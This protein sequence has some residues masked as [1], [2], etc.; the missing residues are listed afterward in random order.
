MK[1]ILLA[2][3][4]VLTSVC[5]AA[6]TPE[7]IRGTD[8]R[9][10]ERWVDS[11]YRAM[12]PRQRVAQIICGKAVPTQGANSRAA[13]KRLVATHR[14]GALLFTS[15]SLAQHIEMTNY[16]QSIAEVP[17]LMTFDGEWG[18]AMRMEGT[19]KFPANMTLGAISDPQLL[20][21][22][23][24]EVG[25]QCRLAGI[26]VNFAPDVD[27][28]SNPRNPVIGHRSF[29]EDP[30]RVATAG[31]AYARGLEHAGVLSVAKHFPGHGDTANDSHKE[32]VRVDHSRQH[33]DDVDLLPFR[34]YIDAGLSGVMVGHIAVPALDPSGRPASMSPA[35]TGMLRSGLRFEGLIFTDALEMKGARLPGHNSALEALRA[36]ADILLSSGNPAA[37]INAITA[38]LADGSLDES[39]ISDRC[40]RVLRYKYALGL[41]SAPGH[42]GIKG[43]EHRLDSPSSRAT[44]DRLAAG[45]I[46]VLRNDAG[47]LPIGGLATA[48]IAVVNIGQPAR[49][50]F[51][52]VCSRYALTD[53][54]TT[55]LSE[56]T[57]ARL[58]GYDVVIAAVYSDNAAARN[59]YGRLSDIKGLVSVF[60]VSPYKM[61]KFHAAIKPAK[62]LVLA[63]EPL[64]C[65]QQA[66]AMAIF[67]G[68]TTS[69]RLPVDLPGI[70]PAGTGLRLRKSRLG[71]SS[72]LAEGLDPALTDSI[73][74]IIGNAL[75]AGAFPGAQVLVARHGNIVHNRSYGRL[76]TGGA[77]VTDSTVYDLAS[78]SKAVGTL[79]GV[80]KAV[81]LGLLRLEKPAADYIPGLKGT[82]KDSITLR[83]LL[84]HE[85]AMPAALNMFNVM[86]DSTSYTGKLITPRR[87]RS[88]TI[89]IYRG[90]WGNSSARLRSDIISRHRSPA[91]PVEAARG[92]W[93]G[94]A[95]FDTIMERI[96]NIPL[97]DTPRYNYSCLNFCLLMDAEQRVTGLPH[98]RWVR[99]SI[100]APLG[101]ATICYRPSL[102]LPVAK[103]APTEHDS[104][105][106][107]QTVR[108]HVHDE[109]AAFIGGVSGNAGVFGSASDLA[110]I[111]QMWLY[112]GHYGDVRLLSEATVRLFTTDKSPTCRRGLGFDKPDTDNPDNSPT[113]DEASAETFGHLGFTG[114][115]FWVD[116]KEDIIFI[117]LT[118]RVN[119][120]R[121]TPV[122]NRLNIRP[123]LFAQVYRS[124]KSFREPPA[125]ITAL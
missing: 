78:V 37:D 20:F 24:A 74:S 115:V 28:N 96:Y 41:A 4:L 112:G 40:R 16:A 65:L 51:S 68:I 53:T 94:Q 30:A 87:D 56:S 104:F 35:I 2:A 97:R 49:N 92:L 75:R 33:L 77:R 98:D 21:S 19:P 36:G 119:P 93:V 15:G 38:A 91:T 31:V 71:Y 101:A 83:Q 54:Y 124:I 86:I 64:P 100:W 80:M 7:I 58:R 117:F 42:I 18:L 105:L 46:T 95:A 27:V 32:S 84:Y 103:I 52:D 26:H 29:G 39:V 125:N 13:I 23:G 67:G 34:K 88:H 11:V 3:A 25:R 8:T 6:V 76:T 110:K 57:I 106:R 44:L 1:A 81:D 47:I 66:A 43:L 48:R 113:C 9:A 59:A 55:P 102:S 10:C 85:S 62:T 14:V 122:F 111:C 89:A 70:A 109:T 69:G 17:L 107:R 118:N 79:P 73:D 45:A 99:D 12:T 108:G 114:T 121:D 5:A 82:G 116:P 22:Y 123:A 90:S 50:E 72:P 120:T 61:D 63:Y 60:M